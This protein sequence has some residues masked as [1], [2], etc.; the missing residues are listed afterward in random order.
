MKN[1]YSKKNVKIKIEINHHQMKNLKIR[2]IE[3]ILNTKKIGIC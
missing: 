1:V 2:C 3:K